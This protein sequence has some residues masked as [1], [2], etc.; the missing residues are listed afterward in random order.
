M[1][2]ALSKLGLP[3]HKNYPNIKNNKKY[4]DPTASMTTHLENLKAFPKDEK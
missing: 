1:I 3:Q 2:K 4:E